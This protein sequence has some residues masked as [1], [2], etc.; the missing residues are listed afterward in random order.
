MK[1]D[2]KLVVVAGVGQGLGVGLVR[3]FLDKNCQ[4][5]GLNR[6]ASQLQHK[7]YKEYLV[8]ICDEV[9]IDKI[10]H[11]IFSEQ[12]VP[13]VLIHNTQKLVIETIEST[14]LE[15][16]EACWRAISLSAFLLSKAFL[17]AMA[18]RG[19]GTMIV[20]GATA[21]LR[22]GEKFS[23]FSSAKFALRG[24][25]QSLARCYQSQGLHIVHV[26]LDGI[27][28]TVKSRELHNME[29]ESMMSA[30]DIAEVYWQLI[31]QPKSTW[32]HELDLRPASESF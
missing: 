15:Q 21:S 23:A 4:V 16:F 6:S 13:D 11:N 7:C 29:S 8:D 19:Q 9:A 28:N 26:V 10:K 20:S 22:G 17:P 24:L 27:V 1:P 31:Q 25:T 14:S 12:G 18:Q 5:I 2:K 3:F 30:Y 32:T